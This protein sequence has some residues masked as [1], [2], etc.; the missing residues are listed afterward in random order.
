MESSCQDAAIFVP[1]TGPLLSFSAADITSCLVQTPI[2]YA[3][4][5]ALVTKCWLFLYL[6]FLLPKEPTGR[7]KLLT[8]AGSLSSPKSVEVLLWK[9][10]SLLSMN[11]WFWKTLKPLSLLNNSVVLVTGWV[12]ACSVASVMS[13]SLWPCELQPTRLLCPW[14]S[15]SKNIGVGCH[16]FLQ[17]IFQTQGLNPSLCIPG[18][19]FT[20][21]LPG[22]PWLQAILWY[23]KDTQN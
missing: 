21:E 17:G 19:F 14:D 6:W 13:D 2:L 5:H 15:P 11:I 4:D 18:G 8:L 16:V 23:S 1:W 12:C 9:F 22:S 10:P 20:A 3:L 7:A